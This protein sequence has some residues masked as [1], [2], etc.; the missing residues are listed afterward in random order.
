M[1]TSLTVEQV[2]LEQLTLD[3]DNVRLHDAANIDAIISSL[4]RFGQV[5]PIVV[6]NSG[7]VLAGNGTLTAAERLGWKTIAVVRTPADWSDTQAM[8][9]AIADNRTAEL[10]DWNREVLASQLVDLQ[11]NDWNLNELGFIEAPV[12]ENPNSTTDRPE[13]GKSKHR[14]LRCP[15]CAHSWMPGA[16]VS[17]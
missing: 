11:A 6:T 10:A 14:L 3:P 17:A 4:S 2:P 8:A 5:K 1:S 15:R 7:K 9:Y 12:I 13:P 16:E